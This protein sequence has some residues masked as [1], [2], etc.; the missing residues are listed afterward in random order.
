[1]DLIVLATRNEGKVR[2]FLTLL[3]GHAARVESLRGRP[4]VVLPPETGS[5]YRE[6]AIAKARAVYD[7]LGAPALGDDSGLEVDALGEAPG[8][9]SARYAGP[10]ANDRANNERLLREL[11][12]VPPARRTA[13]FW[14]ALAL[15]RDRD[16]VVLSEGVCEGRI[17]D[18][19]RG[20]GGFGYDPLFVPDGETLTFA[21]LPWER[22]NAISHRAR[23]VAA[24][25]EA[26]RG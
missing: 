6:N 15:V 17:L 7:A 4:Q 3:E 13:R 24:L 22:K 8:I 25:R 16:D 18:A 2:E 1:L 5:T 14:C 11:Q 26:M 9:L 19:P 10:L 23:A 20:E 21:E 12:D